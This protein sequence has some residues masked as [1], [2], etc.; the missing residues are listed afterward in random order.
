MTR[1]FPDLALGLPGIDARILDLLVF[2]RRTCYHSSMAGSRSLKKVT[3]VLAPH[4]SYDDL[5]V[6]AGMQAMEAYETIIDPQTSE[7][8]RDTLR[9]NLRAYCSVDTL[10]MVEVFKRLVAE[11]ER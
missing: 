4:L 11:A 1:D 6:H 5:D 7:E 9:S 8:E 3:P 10:A 2:V